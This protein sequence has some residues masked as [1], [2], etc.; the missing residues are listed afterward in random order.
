M[1]KKED[2]R[3]SAMHKLEMQSADV[4]TMKLETLSRAN[5]GKGGRRKEGE[6]STKRDERKV[7]RE[8][9]EKGRKETN[10]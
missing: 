10:V 8:R 6:R 2:R 1:V 7:R 9:R 4:S 5:K 3:G